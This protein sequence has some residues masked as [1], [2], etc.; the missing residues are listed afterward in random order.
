MEAGTLANGGE[1]LAARMFFVETDG[2]PFAI[3]RSLPAQ[4]IVK[5]LAGFLCLQHFRQAD[6]GN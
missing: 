6:M 4:A 1:R 3:L 2:L 5:P